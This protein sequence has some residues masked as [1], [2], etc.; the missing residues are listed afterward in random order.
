MSKVAGANFSIFILACAFGFNAG[1][2][3]AR[4]DELQLHPRQFLSH[5]NI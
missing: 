3:L 4:L 2:R 5:R 1:Q